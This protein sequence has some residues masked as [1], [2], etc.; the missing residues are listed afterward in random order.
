[1]AHPQLPRPV[2]GVRKFNKKI[3]MKTKLT[4][5]VAVIAVALFAMGCV[6]TYHLNNLKADDTGILHSQNE[7]LPVTGKVVEYFNGVLAREFMV[8][9]GLRHGPYR[10][11]HRFD[12]SVDLGPIYQNS[13]YENGRLVW[14][15]VFHHD[16][17]D[18]MWEGT[19]NYQMRVNGWNQDRTPAEPGKEKAIEK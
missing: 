18:G 2:E 16:E 4:L 6:R 17:R 10:S 9:N 3:I 15:E 19:K 1:M 11:W 8:K 12:R 14:H 13:V 7:R 5:F